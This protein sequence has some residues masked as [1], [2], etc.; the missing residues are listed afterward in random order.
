MSIWLWI[1]VVFWVLCSVIAVMGIRHNNK[2]QVDPSSGR[3]IG[4]HRSCSV[5]RLQEPK[6]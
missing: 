6:R 5:S 1:F 2:G 4:D 3:V